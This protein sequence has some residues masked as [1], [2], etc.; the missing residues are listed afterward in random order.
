[1]IIIISLSFNWGTQFTK[2]VFIGSSDFFPKRV[3][4][5][6]PG[7][8]PQ[9]IVF[10]SKITTRESIR[11]HFTPLVGRDVKKDLGC[12]LRNKFSLQAEERLG[13]N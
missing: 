7:N 11:F 5:N 6:V 8:Q 9:N 4:Q 1:M 2:A 10:I 13:R 3:F 12:V